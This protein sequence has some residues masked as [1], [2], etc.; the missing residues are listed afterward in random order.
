[1]LLN[2]TLLALSRPAD[3]LSA[4]AIEPIHEHE[5]RLREQV[6]DFIAAGH[7]QQQGIGVSKARG[8]AGLLGIFIVEAYADLYPDMTQEARL[9]AIASTLLT[10]GNH[11]NALRNGMM[12]MEIVDQLHDLNTGMARTLVE[13]LVEQSLQSKKRNAVARLFDLER[14]SGDSH[15]SYWQLLVDVLTERPDYT[16]IMTQHFTQ[17]KRDEVVVSHMMPDMLPFI[18]L[19]ARGAFVATELSV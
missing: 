1:M 6:R 14:E 15:G 4:I 17:A 19:M 7:C 12:L 3:S 11:L 8:F 5:L 18:S 9:E 2:Q 13:Q 10:L 16:H